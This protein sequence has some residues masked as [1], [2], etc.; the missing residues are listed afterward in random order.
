MRELRH[1]IERAVILSDGQRISFSGLDHIPAHQDFSEP[2]GLLPWADME[3][4][5]LEKVLKVTHWK[6][7]GRKGAAAI[8]GLKPTTLFFRMKKLG[9][10]K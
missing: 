1:F 7:S 10:H 6:V 2:G 9:L 5:Y 3:R 8:L 4:D